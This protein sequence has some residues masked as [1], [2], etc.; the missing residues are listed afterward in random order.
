MKI[1]NGILLS[2]FCILVC[3]NITPANEYYCSQDTNLFNANYIY[4]TSKTTE[5]ECE[6]LKDEFFAKNKPNGY[7]NCVKK[8]N[9][10]KN[11]FTKG[12]CTPILTKTYTQGNSKCTVHYY[13]RGEKLQKTQRECYG[14]NTDSLKSQIDKIY[15]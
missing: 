7:A 6:W 9:E 15:E 8:Y 10:L 11:S 1:I 4:D 14:T 2:I 3:A 5:A 13:K 12:I